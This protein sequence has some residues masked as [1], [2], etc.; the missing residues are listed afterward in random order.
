MIIGRLVLIP[1]P[2]S[3]F[4]AM[5]VTTPSGAILMNECGSSGGGAAAGP[6][7]NTSGPSM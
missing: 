6:W 3:G 7:A 2:I 4:F 1:C 5:I